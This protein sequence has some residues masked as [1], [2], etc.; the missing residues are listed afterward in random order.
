MSKFDHQT[1]KRRLVEVGLGLGII[2]VVI[3]ITKFWIELKN[4][5]RADSS[6]LRQSVA[7]TLARA[8]E[9]RL[10]QT[11]GAIR[12]D[13]WARWLQ[14]EGRRR[15]DLPVEP[16]HQFLDSFFIYYQDGIL[17]SL[18]TEFLFGR[19]SSFAPTPGAG[20]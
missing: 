8:E 2:L 5:K 13:L 16:A 6:A 11:S 18:E 14:S 19:L 20:R 4:T 10:D 7:L 12:V 1:T 3:L 9:L 15:P 17:D